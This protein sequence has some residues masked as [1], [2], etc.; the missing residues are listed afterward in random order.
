MDAR[1]AWAIA[2][3][4]VLAFFL[5][6]GGARMFGAVG[7]IDPWVYTAHIHDYGDSLTRWGR[8]YYSAR[9]AGIWPQGIL[10]Q[11]FGPDGY[12]MARWAILMAYGSG[13]ALYLRQRGSR[14]VAFS[15]G[16]ALMVSAPLLVEL[17]DDYTQ[18][19]AI[20]YTL[21]ALPMLTARRWPL[22]I[23]GGVLIG[24]A[25]NAH[26]GIVYLLV[27]L[28]AMVAVDVLIASTAP[29]RVALR[30]ASV[31]GGALVAQIALSVAMAARFGWVR[32]NWLFQEIQFSTSTNLAGGQAQAWAVP[33]NNAY[34]R[35]TTMVLV[36]A[37]FLTIV[38][39]VA[40]IRRLF[41]WQDLAAPAAGSAVLV[42]LILYSHFVARIGFVGYHWY[43]VFATT[44]VTVAAWT[45]LS[46][47]ARGRVAPS[48]GIGA[49]L[50]AA[51]VALIVPVLVT[52]SSVL[53][54]VWWGAVVTGA[55]ALALYALLP[56]DRSSRA[57]LVVGA[58]SLAGVLIPLS[59]LPVQTGT[60]AL[61]GSVTNADKNNA[62]TERTAEGVHS[63]AIQFLNVVQRE[64][65]AG[66][67][68][69][70]YYPNSDAF[71]SIQSTT[72]WGYS[73]ID[74]AAGAPAFPRFTSLGAEQ[75]RA[76]GTEYLVFIA[77]SP[78]ELQRV[79]RE[80]ARL[81]PPF[82]AV[83]EAGRITGGDQQ[84]WTGVSRR[85]R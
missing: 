74:C 59:P 24:L 79:Q 25:V 29:K 44:F 3:L 78:A 16:A 42:G 69:L 5:V 81:R 56:S 58:V 34:L 15:A 63:M 75:I 27:P 68:F 14:W 85:R 70:V 62:R 83:G 32:S 6:A 64:V 71:R 61:Y 23:G 10:E 53:V 12:R 41:P 26:E 45:V 37:A 17:R 7:Y 84:A 76:T 30:A 66:D 39:L 22:A 60:A 35:I 65:P 20:A 82:D 51:M 4:G 47:V 11:A 49:L 8:T 38:L 73:C 28:L 18:P 1:D 13:I 36:A 77:R 31:L 2:G 43:L 57:A 48:V 40:R 55:G 80:A 54:A 19:T 9:V 33:W 21:A 72:L 46:A 67:P 50:L 52:S